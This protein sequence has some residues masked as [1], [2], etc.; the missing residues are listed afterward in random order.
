MNIRD[1]RVEQGFSPASKEQRITAASAA[2][3]HAV[4]TSSST[5]GAKALIVPAHNAGL[6]AC[7]TPFMNN[8]G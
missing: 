1:Y 3:V 8:P 5:A 2:E 7:S 4:W 6:K